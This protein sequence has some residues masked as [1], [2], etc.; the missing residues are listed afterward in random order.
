[1]AGGQPR[2]AAAAH[3]NSPGQQQQQHQQ[4]HAFTR[5]SDVQPDEH[6]PRHDRHRLELKAKVGEGAFASVY[7]GNFDTRT[8]AVAVKVLRPHGGGSG[9]TFEEARR[10]FF[11]EAQMLRRCQHRC[12]LCFLCFC[13]DVRAAVDQRERKKMRELALHLIAALSKDLPLSPPPLN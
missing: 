2:V 4:G 9:G 5:Q 11:R 6:D 13:D 3:N 8:E 12:V 1:M 10:L 7:R